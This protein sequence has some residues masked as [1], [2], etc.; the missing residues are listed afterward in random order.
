M[1][2]IGL[3]KICEKLIEHKLASDT[4]VALIERGTTAD[5]RVIISDLAGISDKVR[6]LKPKPPTLIII[7][8]VV[9]LHNKFN[10]VH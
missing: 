2:L 3:P 8:S 5:H 9:S 7:G 6:E 10:G 1:G 4:P